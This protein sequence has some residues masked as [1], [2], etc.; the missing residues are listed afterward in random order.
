M[1]PGEAGWNSAGSVGAVS[2][3]ELAEPLASRPGAQ[4]GGRVGAARLRLRALG[5]GV[6]ALGLLFY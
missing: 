6:R 4:R 2:R 1:P 5:H 3:C